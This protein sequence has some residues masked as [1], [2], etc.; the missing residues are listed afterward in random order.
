MHGVG[1]DDN[2]VGDPAGV[3]GRVTELWQVVLV[4]PLLVVV[5]VV[6]V[7]T[8]ETVA[9]AA[10][11]MGSRC[12]RC[13]CGS[14]WGGRRRDLRGGRRGQ[15][16]LLRVKKWEAGVGKVSDALEMGKK[17]N[18]EMYRQCAFAILAREP[19]GVYHVI[20]SHPDN[21]HAHRVVPPPARP[22]NPTNV[23]SSPSARSSR[24]A[25]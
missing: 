14:D 11:Y 16:T 21:S 6:V 5:V 12:C 2:N 15:G 13:G 22:T 25:G 17:C 23:P 7:V 8:G 24:R 9:S 20:R 4:L 1:D 19:H 18:K 10:P 3:G